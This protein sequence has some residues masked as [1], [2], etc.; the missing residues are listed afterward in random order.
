VIAIRPR[1]RLDLLEQFVYLAEKENVELAEC[2]MAAVDATFKGIAAHP[3]AGVRYISGI[4]QL[5]GTRRL[6]V[7]EFE[8]YLVFYMPGSNGIDIVG[9]LHET[10]DIA[11]IMR[12]AESA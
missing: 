8:N 7:R 4:G 6:P 12:R 5:R 11:R 3:L 9:V 1:A 10:R 2:F